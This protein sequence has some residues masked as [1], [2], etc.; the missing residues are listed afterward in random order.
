MLGR[1][2]CGLGLHRWSGWTENL[3][4]WAM[5][6]QYR[7]CLRSGCDKVRMGQE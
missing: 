2:L 5:G 7:M 6:R 3:G 4:A 1:V